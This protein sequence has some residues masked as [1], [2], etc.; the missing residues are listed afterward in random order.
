MSEIFA[1]VPRIT[2][3]VQ[4]YLAKSVN[5]VPLAAFD[6]VAKPTIPHNRARWTTAF[7][8]NLADGAQLFA[9]DQRI[10]PVSPIGVQVDV[11]VGYVRSDCRQGFLQR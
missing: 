9:E 3:E 11:T 10:V 1:V 5:F 4:N 6:A 7:D 8:H 2:D